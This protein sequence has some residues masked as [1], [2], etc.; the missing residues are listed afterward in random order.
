M[1]GGR[2]TKVPTSLPGKLAYH[3]RPAS[4]LYPPSWSRRKLSSRLYSPSRHH[5][6]LPIWEVGHH[7]PSWPYEKLAPTLYLPSWLLLTP[8]GGGEGGRKFC[9]RIPTKLFRFSF[10]F[11]GRLCRY[12]I[13]YLATLA[14]S[15]RL[16]FPFFVS[17]WQLCFLNF[18]DFAQPGGSPDSVP[19]WCLP[20]FFFSE[21]F[22]RSFQHAL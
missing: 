14:L 13:P 8:R 22:K 21:T 19:P 5:V 15:E 18:V 10:D 20:F 16:F 6:I 11:F 9:K 2:G 3:N 4:L 1:Q 7:S 17:I 12:V